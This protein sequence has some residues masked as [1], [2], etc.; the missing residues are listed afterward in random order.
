M[1]ARASAGVAGLSE[2]AAHGSTQGVVDHPVW[3]LVHALATLYDPA[4]GRI[5]VEGFLD[6]LRHPT[7]AEMAMIG[8]LQRVSRYENSLRF[9]EVGR[10]RVDRF[11]NDLSG[12][13]CF[14]RYCFQPTMN[15]EGVVAGFT[16]PGTPSWTLPNV[17]R[18]TIATA[19]PPTW[20]RRRAGEPFAAISIVAVTRTSK[21]E[22]STKCLRK[23]SN[24]IARS[25]GIGDERLRQP[26]SGSH[27]LAPWEASAD[28][29]VTSRGSL[30]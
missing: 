2:T 28:L 18:C 3:R 22:R 16:G 8:H 29:M 1:S 20:S 17:A 9:L 5:L 15:I 24:R 30:D 26:E 14:A 19:C 27:H 11:V 10:V 13:S 21:Y 23:H 6:S 12:S 4:N 7:E 25:C